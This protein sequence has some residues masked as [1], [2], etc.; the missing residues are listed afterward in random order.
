MSSSNPNLERFVLRWAPGGKMDVN[1]G[2][3]VH[4]GS[5][6]HERL[7]T[8][9]ELLKF[10]LEDDRNKKVKV[11]LFTGSAT[12]EKKGELEIVTIVVLAK[13]RLHTLICQGTKAQQV[14][15]QEL[16]NSYKVL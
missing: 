7:G 14:E 5:E 1:A 16:G 4:F 12:T 6:P 2:S 10:Y 11:G 15:F 13:G 9:D 8:A 3:L